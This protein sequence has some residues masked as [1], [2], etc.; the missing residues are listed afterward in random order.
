MKQI[1]KLS[2]VFKDA[3]IGFALAVFWGKHEG[4]NTRKLIRRKKEK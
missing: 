2:K 4:K 3:G 1:D